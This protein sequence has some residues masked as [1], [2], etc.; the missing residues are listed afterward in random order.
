MSISCT[1]CANIAPWTTYEHCSVRVQTLWLTHRDRV[2]LTISYTHEDI[3]KEM[4]IHV[5]LNSVIT[6]E[7]RLCALV[8]TQFGSKIFSDVRRKKQVLGFLNLL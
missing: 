6:L 3:E 1:N 7:K 8:R 5:E 2:G 4:K